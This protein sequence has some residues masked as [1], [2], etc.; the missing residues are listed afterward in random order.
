MKSTSGKR[1]YYCGGLATSGEHIPPKQ[2]FKAFQCDSITVPSCDEHNSSKSRR[3]QAIVSALLIPLDAGRHRHPLKPEIKLAI[4]TARPSFERA[5]R[6][7]V[8]THFLK[9]P[10]QGLEDLPDLAHVAPSVHIFDW[11]RQLTA[12]I[13]YSGIGS[14]S[15]T[16][17]WSKATVW[18]PEW[19]PTDSPAPVN[20]EDAAQVLKSSH[21]KKLAL[22]S[23]TWQ[24]GW[25]A[26]PKPYPDIIYSFHFHFFA[27]KQVLIRH[28][29]YDSYTWFV[30]F[31]ASNSNIAKLLRRLNDT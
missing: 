18:S 24:R 16:I 19:F 29:L 15:N 28:G 13:I 21:E 22:E 30:Q 10:P 4:E 9:D 8:R 3:D 2:M 1:C 27:N 31:K 12:G 6:G 11:I 23:L 14:A 5:K 25:S 20:I 7:A 26:S 17:R